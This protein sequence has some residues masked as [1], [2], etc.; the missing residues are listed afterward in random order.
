MLCSV[1]RSGHLIAQVPIMPIPSYQFIIEQLAKYIPAN[2]S[3]VKAGWSDWRNSSE[4]GR[5]RYPR[6]QSNV[7]WEG[8]ARHARLEFAE[9]AEVKAIERLQSVGFLIN[10]KILLRF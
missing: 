5:T 8:I 3:A 1:P 10:G 7:V 9:F 2:T 6:T 4:V